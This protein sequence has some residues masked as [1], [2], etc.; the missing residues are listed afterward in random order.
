MSQLASTL[1]P[2]PRSAPSTRYLLR[3]ARLVAFVTLLAFVWSSVQVGL[4][5]GDLVNAGGWTQVA[6]FLRAA[7]RPQ[8]DA[9]F[10]QITFDA[11]L[12]TAGYAVCGLALSLLMGGVGGLLSSEVWWRA[13]SHNRTASAG[14]PWLIARVALSVPRAIHEVIWG[15]FFVIILGLDPLVAILAL[16]IPFGAI[17]AKVFSEILDETNHDAVWALINTGV[18]A[19]RALLYGLLPRALPNLLSYTFYRL[20]CAIRS[21][22]V[23]GV[24]GAGG[25]GYQILLSLQSLRYEEMWT[26]MAALFVLSGLTDWSSA[27]IR[28]M[29]GAPTRLEVNLEPGCAADAAAR[30]RTTSRTKV[31]NALAL[32]AVVLIPVAFAYVKPDVSRLWSP[33]TAALLADFAQAALPPDLSVEVVVQLA[34]LSVQTLAMSIVAIVF[35]G[36][37]GLLLAYVAAKPPH[38]RGLRGIAFVAARG[39]LLLCR[40]VPAPVWALLFLFVLFPGPV[41]GAAAIGMHNLGI[42]GRLIA[43]AVEN[44]DQRPVSAL[45]TQGAGGAHSFVY[46]TLPSTAPQSLAYIFYRWE[47]CV[48]ETVIVGFVGAGGL[49]RLIQ[50]QLSS[51]DYSGLLASLLAMLVLTLIV[52]ALS[53]TARR[54]L[55]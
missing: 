34:V 12:V 3:G 22:T 38:V 31:L 45:K 36:A 37:I 28:A 20:E 33:R 32:G 13:H 6:Q 21:A 14:S 23:L 25:L 47:V 10:L 44:V 43:E 55:R 24:I 4:F 8:L 30:T 5:K 41:P 40:A 54:A 51:F 29:L 15:L 42:L 53:T 17:T 7:L 27:Q 49:G 11:M 26:L 48:R 46:G 18:P 19:L 9:A 35:A 1:H 16:G 2:Q 39:F 52:D 50:E